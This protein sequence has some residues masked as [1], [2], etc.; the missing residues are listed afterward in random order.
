MI[1]SALTGTGIVSRALLQSFP[2]VEPLIAVAVAIGFYKG[3]RYG[4]AAGASG[5]YLSNFLVY[6]GQGPWSLFQ[7][8]GAGAAGLIGALGGRFGDGRVVFFGSMIAGVFGFE[9]AV[10]AGSVTMASLFGGGIGMLV[11]AVPFVVIH[12]VSTCGFGMMLYGS[13][14][15]IGLDQD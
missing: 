11:A 15:G 14:R 2:S 4:I 5:F 9:L 1:V 12:L 8:L 3:P 6:G 10:N 7:L 13:A